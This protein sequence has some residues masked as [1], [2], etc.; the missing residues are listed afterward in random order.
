MLFKLLQRTIT[1]ELID[2]IKILHYL[3]TIVITNSLV[4]N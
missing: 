2:E 4:K 3:R 1:S